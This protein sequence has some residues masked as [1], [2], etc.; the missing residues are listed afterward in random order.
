MAY[1]RYEADQT[2]PAKFERL[3]KKSGLGEKVK[4]K[5]VAIKMHVGSGI[6]FSTIHPVFVKKACY[7]H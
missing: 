5:K 2:L 3:L 6:T 7:I 4:G 1:S